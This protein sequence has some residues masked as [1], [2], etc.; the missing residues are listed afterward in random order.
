[1]KPFLDP[2]P[3]ERALEAL[4]CC[5]ALACLLTG[6]TH[7]VVS[8][9]AA[10]APANEVKQ[11]GG[12]M[13]AEFPDGTKIWVD[14]HDSLAAVADLAGDVARNGFILEGT[15]E[16]IGLRRAKNASDAATESAKIAAGTEAQRI[17]ADQA[18]ASQQLSNEA[19][20]AAAALAAP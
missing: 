16:A 8:G 19:A 1:M 9:P 6:C 3:V 4:I 10:P 2:D 13:A 11:L 5:L 7:V 20:A 17:A 15:K 14:N 12:R 18:L